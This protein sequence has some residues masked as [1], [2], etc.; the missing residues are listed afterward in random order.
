MSENKFSKFAVNYLSKEKGQPYSYT[1]LDEETNGVLVIHPHGGFGINTPVMIDCSVRASFT[2]DHSE[3]I[4]EEQ[5][6]AAFKSHVL[7]LYKYYQD[8]VTALETV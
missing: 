1:A 8:Q 5:F 7:L 4:T 2:I 3:E 6:W